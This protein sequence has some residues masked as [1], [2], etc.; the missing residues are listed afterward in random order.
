M[1][2]PI[3][4]LV[5]GSAVFHRGYHAI[6]HLSTRDGIPTNAVLGFA[7]IIFKVMEALKPTY[8]VVAWDKSSKTFRKE[9]YADYKA[10]RVKQ[11][12]DLYAQIPTTR[13]LVEALNLPWVELENYEADDIIGTLARQAEE[14]GDLDIVIATGDKDQ[15][16]LIDKSTVVD[17]FNPRGLE[18]TRYDLAKM[19][20]RYGLT[21]QQF[22]DYK[23]LVGDT[24]D[25]IPGVKGIGEKGALKL[26]AEYKT[27]EGIYE[28]AD[29]IT[30]SVG[31]KLRVAKDM[32]YLSRKL[33]VIVCDAP[34]KLDLEEAKLRPHD[35]GHL[36]ELFRKLE[37]KS[38]M[39]KLPVLEAVETGKPVAA[40]AAVGTGALTLFGDDTGETVKKNREHLK[41]VKYHTVATKDDLEELAGKLE[42]LEVFA[43]DTETTGVNTLVADLVGI[44]VAFQEGEA[45]YIPVAHVNGTQLRREDVVARLKP[46]WENPKIGKVGHNIKF[47]YEM[48]RKYDVHTAGIVFD[49]MIAGFLLNSAGRSQSLDD[50]AFSE[51]GIE[52]IPISE[53]I[54]LD[55]K[56]QKT[57]DQALIED[58]TTYAAEDADMSW[59]LYG[60]LK[61][62]LHKYSK[63]NEW[64]W[65][66]ERLATEVEWPIVGIL[67]EMELAGIEL[68]TAFLEK[69]GERLTKD[70][71][72][73][74]EQ[75]YDHA[76]EEFNIDSPAQLGQIL[77]GRLGLKADGVK[78]GKTGLSTAAAELEKLKDAHPMVGLV[79]QYREVTKLMNT[80]VTAL[81]E[82][83][84]ADGRVHTNFSQALVPS[85]RLSSNNPNL[86]NIPVRTELGREIRTA[87]V[88]PKGRAL[89]SAD[90]SQIELRVAAAMAGD[91]DMIETFK[92]GMDL[93]ATTAAE[94]Y[95][96]PLDQVTKDQR[97]AVKAV[98]FGV[99]YGMSAHGLSVATGMDMKESQGFIDRYFQ[100]RPKLKEWIEA[101][102]KMAYEEL[103]TATIFDRRRPCPAIQT[104]NYIVRQQEERVAVNVPIQGSAAD[105]YKLA[106]IAVSE[107]LATGEWG[108]SQLLLQIHDELIV[109]CPEDRADDVAAMLKEVM[110][111][112]IDLG[113]PLSVDTAV[114]K[115][116][117]EL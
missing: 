32:A 105:I 38:L 114:G 5:D 23:A 48:L 28:H 87:F 53:L 6:P 43:F 76:G 8:V 68:D 115:N 31:E 113:V 51:L 83:V 52:M 40:V 19:Q 103:Y 86:Q 20:E 110:E 90:Y 25:N 29:E 104:N 45:Y 35:Y 96:V 66:M 2:K 91:K 58:A 42:S 37:F 57:F 75:I 63:L 97:A 13:E 21:P 17:M 22:I 107:K 1:K 36:R 30:G 46:I 89:V 54:G 34:V 88:A 27:L 100:V 69:F 7:N 62:R 70:I 60:R 12:D 72:R 79:M 71:G 11:P 67:A 50:M 16:Q 10:T 24:S 64:G 116:W 81:P 78:K 108:K 109:E 77:Y 49:T 9:M 59:R 112:V 106:M 95:N 56:T 26:L 61:E 65:S 101:T 102:K 82:Q 44:S 33:S 80:Y 99:L 85:G 73:L 3:L 14:R 41:T 84:A 117:G 74:K 4:V 55:K 18:P 111:G 93:H 94:L 39:N 47:D 92:K 98:N 15:L